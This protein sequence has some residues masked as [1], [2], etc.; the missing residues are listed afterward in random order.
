MD[1]SIVKPEIVDLGWIAEHIA[2]Q[3]IDYLPS[4]IPVFIQS[5]FVIS[6]SFPWIQWIHYYSWYANFRGIRVSSLVKKLS[7]VA[8]FIYCEFIFVLYVG[9]YIST[10]IQFYFYK[11][12]K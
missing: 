7:N 11:P 4:I 8:I 2:Q 3:V 9:S 10:K 12:Q 5:N 1:D 6:H